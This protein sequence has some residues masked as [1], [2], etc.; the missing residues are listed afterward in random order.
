MAY[1]ADYRKAAIEYKRNGHTFK[2]LKEA[3]GITPRTCCQ[4]V[5]IPEE[6]G[7]TKP[8]ITRTGREDESRRTQKGCWGET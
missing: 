2:D 6:T 5:E 1:G 4:W 3:F 7:M 8:K